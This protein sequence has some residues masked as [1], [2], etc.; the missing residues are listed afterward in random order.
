MWWRPSSI[1]YWTIGIV[2][3]LVF[4]TTIIWIGFF[5]YGDCNS[6]NS[7]CRSKCHYSGIKNV[8][9]PTYIGNIDNY[10]TSASKLVDSLNLQRDCADAIIT[11]QDRCGCHNWRCWNNREPAA[12]WIAVLVFVPLCIFAVFCTVDAYNRDIGVNQAQTCRQVSPDKI[13]QTSSSS[14]NANPEVSRAWRTAKAF[15]L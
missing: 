10:V 4:F 3:F 8:L 13:E 1:I 6:A 11:L 7:D 5:D 9:C 15:D 12:S 14:S 2:L